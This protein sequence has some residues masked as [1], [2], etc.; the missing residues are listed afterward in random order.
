MTGP[1]GTTPT[2]VIYVP[3]H[4]YVAVCLSG[5]PAHRLQRIGGKEQGHGNEAVPFYRP[6]FSRMKLRFQVQIA[7][8]P[9]L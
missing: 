8:H 5:R 9:K 4:Y 3:G 1:G 7:Y 2:V 6:F